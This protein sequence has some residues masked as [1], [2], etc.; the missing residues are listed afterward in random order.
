MPTPAEKLSQSK[1]SKR[2][3]RKLRKSG[4]LVCDLRDRRLAL[5]LS[6]QDV[7]SALKISVGNFNRIE[8]GGEVGVVRALRLAR[9][10]G[11]TVEAIWKLR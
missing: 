8:R 4:P 7:A 5:S 9:F 11:T 10:F 3:P 6:S 2:S 1:K